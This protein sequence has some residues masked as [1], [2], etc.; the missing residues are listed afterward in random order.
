MANDLG[1]VTIF[2][3]SDSGAA[4]TRIEMLLVQRRARSTRQDRWPYLL[5]SRKSKLLLSCLPVPLPL[6]VKSLV[7]GHSF[8]TC[9]IHMFFMAL[10]MLVDIYVPCYRPSEEVVGEEKRANV[11]KYIYWVLW[12]FYLRPSTWWTKTT[13][14]YK[15]IILGHKCVSG[16]FTGVVA[17]HNH[18]KKPSVYDCTVHVQRSYSTRARIVFFIQRCH[19]NMLAGMTI[20]VYKYKIINFQLIVWNNLINK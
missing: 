13:S 5:G 18:V 16:F 20:V 8:C 19:E 15:T 2:G 17:A 3:S 14:S 4:E 10:L 12:P 6:E 9:H 1:R 11:R 7:P